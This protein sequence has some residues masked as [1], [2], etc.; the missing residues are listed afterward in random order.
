MALVSGAEKRGASG[1]MSRPVARVLAALERQ[2][3]RI[4]TSNGGWQSQCPSHED[5]SPSLSI[6]EGS[7]GRVLLFCFAGCETPAVLRALGLTY[8]DLF[9]DGPRRGRRPPLP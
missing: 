4:R 8:R 9:G 2:G 1:G 6:R 7:D 3:C 5:R